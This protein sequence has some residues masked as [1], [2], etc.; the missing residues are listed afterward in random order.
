MSRNLL[1]VCLFAS[2]LLFSEVSALQ[3]LPRS[4]ELTPEARFWEWHNRKDNFSNGG[5]TR[6]TFSAGYA[7]PSVT[8]IPSLSPVGLGRLLLSATRRV[9]RRTKMLPTIVV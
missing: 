6:S 8:V 7:E 5:F 4:T 3:S 9:V 2:L 1:A